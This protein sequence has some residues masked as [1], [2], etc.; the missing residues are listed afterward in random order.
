MKQRVTYL[1]P[2]SHGVDYADIKVGANGLDF[3][4]ADKAAEE[5][6]LT[7][8]LNDLPDEVSRLSSTFAKDRLL[9]V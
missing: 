6:R 9:N 2:E 8:G 7:L 3:L 5:W 1:L 4:R